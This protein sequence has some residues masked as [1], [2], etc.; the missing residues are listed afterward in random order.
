MKENLR[1]TDICPS[2]GAQARHLPPR[3]KAFSPAQITLCSIHFEKRYSGAFIL[4]TIEIFFSLRPITRLTAVLKTS[5]SA[6]AY[7]K[8]YGAI[9]RPNI[10]ESTSTVVMIKACS[11]LPSASPSSVPMQLSAV[12]SRLT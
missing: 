11:T 5:V 6:T 1:L 9:C 2:S 10:T 3:G 12:L 7:R 4:S 8:L